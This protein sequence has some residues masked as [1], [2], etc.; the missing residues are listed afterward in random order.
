[1]KGGK[2]VLLGTC[3]WSYQ[4]WVELFYPNNRV[5]KLPFY[6]KVFDTVEVDSSFY[7]MPSKSMVKGWARATGPFFKF[8]LKVPKTITHDRHLQ[9]AEGELHK[10]LDV[11]KPLEDAGKLGCLLVQLAPSFT[12]DEVGKLESFLELLPSHMHFAVEFRHESWDRKEAWAL[13]KKHNVAN[14][15]TESP[16]EFL[17]RVV[18]TSSTHAYVRWHGRGKSIWYDYT[19]SR[20]ELEP[21]V[22]KLQQI[23]SKV[24]V[25]YA[26][27]NN[28]YNAGAPYNALEF[29]Q[30][31]G[32]LTEAQEKALARIE[33]RS[34]R[35]SKITDYFKS[36]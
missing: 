1:V 9:D 14:T 23:E 19:Y 35:A 17:S 25:T 3:G 30:M 13:L 28:H 15:I 32:E 11:V 12:Y 29:L 33:R 2:L 31:K 24:P 16:I 7:R 10:F 4:E 36:T 22:A 20:D 34:R 18:L 26:Y 8:S 6:A 5:A 21:W 27:F